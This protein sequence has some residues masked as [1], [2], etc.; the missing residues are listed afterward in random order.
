MGPPLVFYPASNFATF[1]RGL[2]KSGSLNILQIP[3]SFFFVH[4]IK[5]QSIL[6]FTVFINTSWQPSQVARLKPY[7]RSQQGRGWRGYVAH[8]IKHKVC[9]TYPQ[10]GFQTSIRTHNK[11]HMHIA[12]I[13]IM[14]D[15]T[16]PRKIWWKKFSVQSLP[17][18]SCITL[19]LWWG[20][21]MYQLSEL[22]W[23]SPGTPCIIQVICRRKHILQIF[24]MYL[25]PISSRN[26]GTL[27][28]PTDVLTSC[29]IRQLIQ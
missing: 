10:C 21:G 13:Y 5:D 18:L 7:F 24:N 15:I 1:L 20:R 17:I 25:D 19:P 22:P 9:Y 16:L 2:G 14:Y 11:T 23:D 12:H 26:Y 27:S 8:T 29:I 4:W 6:Y 3:I 28:G